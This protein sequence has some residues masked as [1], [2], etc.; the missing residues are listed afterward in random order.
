MPDLLP[1]PPHMFLVLLSLRG[2][3]LHG[4]G[5]KKE[6]LARSGGAIDLDPGG[7]YRLIGRLET[8]G[9]VR[10]AEAP[11][12][13]PD[14]DHRRVF[15]TLTAAGE[16]LLAAEAVRLEALLGSPDVRALIDGA[17]A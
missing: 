2:R 14:D 17:G 12:D 1:L 4:Y 11:A 16:E 10:A 15:Y 8:K 5:I 7:L 13:E 9:V 6:V 3:A